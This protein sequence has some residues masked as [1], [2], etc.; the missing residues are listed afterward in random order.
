MT[1]RQLLA[2]LLVT[3][4]LALAR[5]ADRVAGTDRDRRAEPH[6]RDCM[7]PAEVRP[8]RAAVEQDGRAG[9][10]GAAPGAESRDVFIGSVHVVLVPPYPPTPLLFRGG[11]A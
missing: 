11:D 5:L 7:R 8:A 1:A 9:E 3:G 2:A 10:D 4:A 6:R